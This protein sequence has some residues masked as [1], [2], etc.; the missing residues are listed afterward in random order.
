MFGVLVTEYEPNLVV[1][2]RRRQPQFAADP[3]A[4]RVR[5]D[6]ITEQY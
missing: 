3:R 6:E 1:I 4:D 5:H 2:G